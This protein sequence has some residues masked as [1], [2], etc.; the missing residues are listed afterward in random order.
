[1]LFVTREVAETG[2]VF[3]VLTD[4]LNAYITLHMLGWE[5]LKRQAR[6]LFHGGALPSMTVCPC[7]CRSLR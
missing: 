2:N 7:L 4:L 6:A 5:D 3:H 1:M